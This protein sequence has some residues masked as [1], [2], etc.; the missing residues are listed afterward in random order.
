[1]NGSKQK[2]T[3]E[4]QISNFGV[5]TPELG[6]LDLKIEFYASKSTPGSPPEAWK[7]EID[8]EH[9]TK[10]NSFF[11]NGEKKTIL[12]WPKG[13]FQQLAE[14]PGCQAAQASVQ[15]SQ[16]SFQPVGRAQAARRVSRAAR[17]VAPMPQ[18]E[19]SLGGCF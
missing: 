15:G 9:E 11:L 3:N 14:P 4:Q 6:I 1:M 12:K 19:L 8:L 2:K 7:R 18:I 10:K 13:A 16:A 17:P 5:W